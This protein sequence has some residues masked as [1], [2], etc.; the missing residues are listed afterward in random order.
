MCMEELKRQIS[1]LSRS[2][3]C[4]LKIFAQEIDNVNPLHK[5]LGYK[6]H[7]KL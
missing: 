1:T 4:I 3:K 5:K 7:I 6:M 2:V